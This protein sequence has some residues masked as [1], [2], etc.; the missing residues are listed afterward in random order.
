MRLNV[1]LLLLVSFLPFPTALMVEAID[2]SRTTERTAVI[3]YGVVAVLIERVMSLMRRHAVQADELRGET[4]QPELRTDRRGPIY[5]V[6]YF[7]VVVLGVIL[8]PKA[9]AFAYLVIAGIA[10]FRAHGEGRLL[11]SGT[12]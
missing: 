1:A 4:D 2:R 6:A 7:T 10:V 3:V 8:L 9:A 5:V 11:V 12:R